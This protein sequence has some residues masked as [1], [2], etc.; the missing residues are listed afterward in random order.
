VKISIFNKWKDCALVCLALIC[1]FTFLCPVDQILIHYAVRSIAKDFLCLEQIT[2]SKSLV[3][4][5]VL[6]EVSRVD[7]VWLHVKLGRR[8]V[9]TPSTCNW[10]SPMYKCTALYTASSDFS[11]LR[12]R[13]KP[14]WRFV[15]LLKRATASLVAGLK[16]L[17]QS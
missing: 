12:Q 3:T 17:Q 8:R 5:A 11:V 14:W 9:L 2:E 15:V 16:N 6:S 4:Y 7:N 10:H 13:R 1:Y